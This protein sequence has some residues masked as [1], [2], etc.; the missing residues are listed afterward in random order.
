MEGEQTAPNDGAF[1]TC[2]VLCK[3]STQCHVSSTRIPLSEHHSGRLEL[4][5][6]QTPWRCG[7]WEPEVTLTPS[8]LPEQIHPHF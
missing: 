1:P 3:S 8:L 2:R 6:G 4:S 5:Q 7:G